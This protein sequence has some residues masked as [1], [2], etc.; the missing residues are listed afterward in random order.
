MLV[1]LLHN[2]WRTRA[3]RKGPHSCRNHYWKERA[4]HFVSGVQRGWDWGTDFFKKPHGEGHGISTQNTVVPYARSRRFFGHWRVMITRH[5]YLKRQRIDLKGCHKCWEWG[6]LFLSVIRKQSLL[7]QDCIEYHGS[8]DL[9]AVLWA[10]KKLS[11]RLQDIGPQPRLG[12]IAQHQTHRFTGSL[13]GWLTYFET[14]NLSALQA[15]HFSK[16]R[17]ADFRCALTHRRNK[18]PRHMVMTGTWA[19][20]QFHRLHSW[21]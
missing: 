14:Q 19:G 2:H 9:I 18:F 10:V 4:R 13:K 16:Q 12:M 7:A 15:K 5:C 6:A 11:W 20:D 21:L 1:H 8:G 17:G 3:T